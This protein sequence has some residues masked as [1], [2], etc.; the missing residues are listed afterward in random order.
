[1]E[2]VATTSTVCVRSWL[3]TGRGDA[4]PRKYQDA[5]FFADYS[6]RCIWAM[7]TGTDGVPDPARTNTFVAG[8]AGLVDLE[9]GPDDL[10]YVSL[11]GGTVHRIT[12]SDTNQPPVADAR[13]TPTYGETPLTVDFDGTGSTDPEGEAILYEWDFTGDGTVAATDA[14]AS[15]TYEEAGELEA[16]LAVT[17]A[18][19]ARDTDTVKISPGNTPPVA[20]IERPLATRTWRVGAE[21]PFSG[22]ASDEQD[23]TLAPAQLS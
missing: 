7:K 2:M 13:A 15:D 18:Q 19:G 12:Y 20:Q 3:G 21:I 23:S 6:R 5:L 10:Y 22:T 1:M 17:D 11:N 14:T 8:A 16:S 4:F 9:S